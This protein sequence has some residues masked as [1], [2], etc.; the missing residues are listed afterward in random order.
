MT[1]GGT[2]LSEAAKEQLPALAGIAHDRTAA[3]RKALP[4]Y[5]CTWL[6]TLKPSKSTRGQLLR[7]VVGTLQTI[8]VGCLQTN[9]GII[10]TNI[11][12]R[13]LLSG[14]GDETEG[15]R[16]SA[17]TSLRVLGKHAVTLYKYSKVKCAFA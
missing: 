2:D 5:I 11:I 16:H 1:N 8:M 3:L 14:V 9:C 6:T 4:P 13:L 12:F 10:D 17:L 15:V 7:Y